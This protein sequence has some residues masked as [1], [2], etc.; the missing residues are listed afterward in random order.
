MDKERPPSD[1]AAKF[2]KTRAAD[3]DRQAR[4]ALA[5]YEA[6]HEL[7]TCV[8]AAAIG[9]GAEKSLLVVG[10]GTG[11]EIITIG[12]HRPRWRFLAVDPSAP[13][14]AAA[15]ARLG[16][17]GLL[18]RVDLRQGGVAGLPPDR[19]DGAT[20]IGVLHHLKGD[21][22]RLTLLREIAARLKPGAP[23]VLACNCCDYASEPLL[24]AAWQERWRMHGATAA[25]VKEK[26]ATITRDVEPPASEQAVF[27]LL[28]SAGFVDPRRFF[29]SLFWGS[30]VCRRA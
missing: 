12:A 6:C 17:L 11:Q 19:H 15:R 14:A 22:P 4:I 26:F 13:M 25:E 30:W 7:T 21:E 1:S 3:Y 23:F 24:V 28:H 10:V 8:L 18:D 27:D 9:T 20:L 29:S 5:G 16:A 2:D